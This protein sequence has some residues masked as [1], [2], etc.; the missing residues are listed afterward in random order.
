MVNR[1]HESFRENLRKSFDWNDAR[2]LDTHILARNMD[3]DIANRYRLDLYKSQSDAVKRLTRGDDYADMEKMR[4]K[5]GNY[6]VDAREY[7]LEEDL[8]VKYFNFYGCNYEGGEIVDD[9]NKGW[10]CPGCHVKYMTIWKC[11]PD[12]CQRCGWLT[13]IGEMKRDGA[14]RRRCRL[15]NPSQ[16]MAA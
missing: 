4:G 3:A 10:E 9:Q 8:A 16:A 6:V 7:A 1:Y 5:V 12:R 11:L 2:I 15:R 13:P 14:F